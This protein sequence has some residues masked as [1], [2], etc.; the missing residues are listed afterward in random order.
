[1]TT[2]YPAFAAETAVRPLIAGNG[3]AVAARTS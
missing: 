1:M 3:L 2:A